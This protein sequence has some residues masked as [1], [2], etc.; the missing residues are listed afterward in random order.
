LVALLSGGLQH[1]QRQFDALHG[2]QERGHGVGAG[3]D[4]VAPQHLGQVEVGMLWRPPD[5]IGCV[6][7]LQQV[8]QAL[9]R[10][11]VDLAVC[12]LVGP[13]IDRRVPEGHAATARILV[14][15]DFRIRPRDLLD[16]ILKRLPVRSRDYP[17]DRQPA[18]PIDG[19]DD[20]GLGKIPAGIFPSLVLLHVSPV[21]HDDRFIHLDRP[22]EHRR[23]DPRAGQP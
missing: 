20:D 16:E 3:A 19:A 23:P 12:E 22:G 13:V 5:V 2:E 14:G 4:V 10:V 21:G 15:V 1:S 8:P 9:D 17:C 6:G 18:G 11:G 7:A